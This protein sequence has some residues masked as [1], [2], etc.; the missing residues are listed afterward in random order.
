MDRTYFAD[1]MASDRRFE[2]RR[3]L[4]AALRERQRFAFPRGLVA[5]LF[6]LFGVR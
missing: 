2:E 4:F 6:W 1:M 3:M 5:S